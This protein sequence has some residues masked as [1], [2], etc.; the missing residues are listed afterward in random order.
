MIRLFTTRDIPRCLELS[1]AAG[2]NQTAADW[3]RLTILEPEGCFGWECDGRLVATSTLLCYGRDL[4][5]LGMVLTDA[6]YQRRGFARKL[7]ESALSLADAR[8]VRCVK[9]DATDQGRPLYASLG[10]VDEQPV[11]R[12]RADW[13]RVPAS[14]R[15]TGEFPV[16][17][18]RRAFGADRSA[19]LR[20]AG[21][22]RCVVDGYAITRPGTRASYLGPCVAANENIATM[23]V[24]AALYEGPWYWDILTANTAA[25]Q[26]AGDF[27]FA[28]VRKLIRMVRGSQIE[29]DDSRVY[30]IGGFEAG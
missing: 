30:A 6:A 23:L 14:P 24:A 28:P 22:L 26:L 13:P 19:F 25:V 8:G 2:W 20:S 11:E 9:L 21:V 12:W 27:G 17:L 18:D 3:E 4:A 15:G 16:R 29:R 1:T 10:F 7:V 5:W